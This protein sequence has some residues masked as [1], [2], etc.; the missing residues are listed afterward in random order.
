[1]GTRVSV[2]MD[3]LKIGV[4]LLEAQNASRKMGKQPSRALANLCGHRA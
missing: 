1:M 2:E 4:C 3:V